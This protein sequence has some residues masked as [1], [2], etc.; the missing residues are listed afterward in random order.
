MNERRKKRK[1]GKAKQRSQ[2]PQKI[3]NLESM[4]WTRGRTVLLMTWLAINNTAL[5]KRFSG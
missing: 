1:G 4:P 3:S 2:Q 5:I